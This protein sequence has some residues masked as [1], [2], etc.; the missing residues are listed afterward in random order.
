MKSSSCLRVTTVLPQVAFSLNRVLP[1]VHRGFGGDFPRR[2]PPLP[3]QRVP[4]RGSP[5]DRGKN[6]A[7]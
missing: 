2:I 5:S 1:Q 6:G 4:A 7:P 3:P